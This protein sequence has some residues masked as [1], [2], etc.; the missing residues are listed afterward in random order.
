MG[1]FILIEII[2]SLNIQGEEM[3]KI[4]H[5]NK[6]YKSNKVKALDDINIEIKKGDI[7][8][9]VGLS[10]AGKSSLVRCINRLE[11][12][13]SGKIIINNVDILSLSKKELI[14]QRK[15]IGM[16]FQSFNLFSSKTIF[17]NI[18]YPLRLAKMSEDKIKLRVEELLDIV[19][20]KEKKDTYPSQLSGGQKQRVG[21]A[22]AIANNPDVLLCDEA[23]S[24]LD[25]KTTAQILDLLLD[26]NR[27]T[28]L[29]IVVI[30]HEMEVIKHICN[31]VAII[32][33]G[34]IIDSGRVIDL[35]S[36]P[37]NE[38]TKHFVEFDYNI[39]TKMIRGNLLSL[40]FTGD[41]ATT[42]I[43][44][45][46][47]RQY[48]VDISIISGNIDYIQGEPLGK[49]CVEVPKEYD[50]SAIKADFQQYNVRVEEI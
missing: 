45:K 50:L 5:L 27:K 10:G 30:T 8:G 2:Q 23:T 42:G 28:K 26:I 14:E 17:E 48:N 12:A 21:I 15:K 35:F 11:E 3:I 36:K 46:I 25:P 22:R 7:Y 34:K 19:E 13:D 49:L 40:T 39:P 1:I 37:A 24:A 44:S 33:R 4:E 32:E 41:T 38:R 18:A 29:T 47:S 16:I 20:L 43:I 6:T 9:I 31:K